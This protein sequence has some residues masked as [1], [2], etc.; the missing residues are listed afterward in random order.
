MKEYQLTCCYC[1]QLFFVKPQRYRSAKWNFKTIGLKY[2]CSKPCMHHNRG[3]ELPIKVKCM[4]C[5]TE[6]L[7]QACELKKTPNSFCNRSCAATFNNTHKKHGTKRS[8]LEVYLEEQLVIK[9]PTLDFCF[10]KK[11]AINSELDIYLPSLKLAFEL[12]GIYHYEPIHGQKK[13][14]QIQNNDNRKFQACLEKHIEL[15]IIDTSSL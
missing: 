5:Q 6:F 8:K 4:N 14:D 9:Y 10:N 2:Y 1:Q 7:K 11:D 13:L 12:N 15:C 3:H